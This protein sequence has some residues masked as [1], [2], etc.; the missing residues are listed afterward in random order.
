[1][2][3]T[4]NFDFP[5]NINLSELSAL[6]EVDS[7]TYAQA[8]L[9]YREIPLGYLSTDL[10][11]P[12]DLYTPILDS[13]KQQVT[14]FRVLHKDRRFR[15]EDRDHLIDLGV[16]RF[17]LHATQLSDYIAYENKYANDLIKRTDV[18][19]AEKSQLLYDN[20]TL[21]ISQ[22]ME[23]PRLGEN[24]DL[25]VGYVKTLTD[26]I[27]SSPE[28]I[29][30]ISELLAIDYSLYTHS[31]DVCLLIT[32]FGHYLGMQHRHIVNLGIGGL[33]HDIGKKEI[34]HDILNKAGKLNEAEWYEMKQHPA[35]GCTM[36]RSS[37]KLHPVVY[38]M[39][40]QHHENL[41]GSGYPQGLRDDGITL[42]SRIIRIVDTYDALTSNRVYKTS[43]TPMEAI[44]LIIEEMNAQINPALLKSFISF[45]GWVDNA[46]A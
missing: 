9:N 45:L 11:L 39:V 40:L 18:S 28:N 19:L 33:Y 21:I 36:L 4:I 32:A 12:I 8:V 1:M 3:R 23:D 22:A 14:M 27:T 42:P 25:G 38:E 31:V 15:V 16:K 20:A 30:S 6:A 44:S 13:D 29:Q 41:D 17:F 34:S 37:G 10:V 35:Y 46:S 26:F 7:D 2:E 5:Q 43:L 24:I